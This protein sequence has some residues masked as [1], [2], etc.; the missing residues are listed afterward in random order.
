MR[1]GSIQRGAPSPGTV[2]AVG[3]A[4]ETEPEPLR[5]SLS[6]LDADFEELDALIGSVSEAIGRRRHELRDAAR[7]VDA[8]TRH[9]IDEEL[10]RAAATCRRSR[11]EVRTSRHA[12]RQG[13]PTPALIGRLTEAKR[14]HVNLLRMHLALVGS[15]AIASDWQSPSF[16]HAV[17]SMAGRHTGRVREHE[18]DYKRDRH[19]DAEA[20]EAAYLRHY[21]D[22]PGSLD[23]RALMTSCG[24][25]AFTTVLWHVLGHPASDRPVLMGRNSYHE[26][27]QLVRMALGARVVEVD[28][29]DAGSILRAVAMARPVAVFLDSLCNSKGL[30]L[31][32]LE[33]VLRGLTG[34]DD[35]LV[36]IDNTGRSCIFQPFAM[37]D[38]THH[39][40]LVV[41][42]SLTKFAQLG[43]DR[44][45]AGMIVADG[46][47]GDTLSGLREH[48]G[49]NVADVATYM[50]PA[51]NRAVLE[52]RLQRLDRNA[53]DLAS[54]LNGH[55][56]A[57]PGRVVRG[58]CYSGLA[59]H[60]SHETARTLPFRGG[61]LAVDFHR[62]FDEVR[63]H[64]A[65]VR[66]ALAAA[67][68]RRV[69]LT[70]GASFGLN[71]TRVY[72][73]AS[74]SEHGEP[75][76]RIAVGTEHRCGVQGLVRVF[77]DAIEELEE[78]AGRPR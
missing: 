9:A 24:M 72:H 38:G 36:V 21:V 74:T 49:T 40:R 43:M 47:I 68:H 26:C 6:D 14:V 59:G 19:P 8:S 18:D 66:S 12:A 63:T 45:P 76:V 41:F 51:P 65:F 56:A 62:E 55:V 31:P 35:M 78:A 39:G 16:L 54:R 32:D 57:R 61:L 75:F 60:P 67:V 33:G 71:T 2:G 34:P 53:M 37:A 44:T 20:F 42:E 48:L 46:A 13:D 27:R 50:V 1:A 70:A 73:T 23:L 64:R 17:H 25:A 29:R 52:R 5:A 28:E 58:I 30:I 22:N 15:L 10:S 7:H 4:I 11:A 77:A 69:P 3:A